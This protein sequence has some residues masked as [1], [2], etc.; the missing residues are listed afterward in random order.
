MGAEA[1]RATSSNVSS[2]LAASWRPSGVNVT[3]LD[4]AFTESCRAAAKLQAVIFV[5]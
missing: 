4:L 5:Y 3:F 2:G 1:R